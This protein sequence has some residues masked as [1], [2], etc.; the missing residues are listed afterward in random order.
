MLNSW[1]DEFV[2]HMESMK[3]TQFTSARVCTQ[4]RV[5]GRRCF[6]YPK[7]I[8]AMI[9]VWAS[10]P[11]SGGW[12]RPHVSWPLT[13]TFAAAAAAFERAIFLTTNKQTLCVAWWSNHDHGFLFYCVKSSSSFTK[14]LPDAAIGHIRPAAAA[15][16]GCIASMWAEHPVQSQLRAQPEIELSVWVFI[17]TH[18]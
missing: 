4:R 7:V 6:S 15:A 16:A 12:L 10:A 11:A 3:Q 14:Q 9:V 1:S 8:M 18:S 13:S 17:F 2:M 5:V